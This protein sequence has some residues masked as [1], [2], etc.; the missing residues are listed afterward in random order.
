MND[1]GFEFFEFAGVS[2]DGSSTA[3][4]LENFNI[5]HLALLRGAYHSTLQS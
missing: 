2:S 3:E 1:N 4:V 5:E